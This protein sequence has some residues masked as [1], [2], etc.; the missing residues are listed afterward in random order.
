[1]I[2]VFGANTDEKEF[3]S[4][5]ESIKSGWMGLGKKV[6]EFETILSDKLGVPKITMVD[7]GSNALYLAIKSLNLPPNSI[8]I[9]P[10]FTWVACANA[11]L[12]AGHRIRFCDVE[13]D[14]NISERKIKEVWDRYVKAIMIVHYAGNPVDMDSINNF[15]VPV[16]EDCAHAVVS[17]YKGTPVGILGD[18]GIYSFD[19]VK[20]LAT[21]EGGAVVSKDTE[22]LNFVRQVRYCG[23]NKSGF[24]NVKKEKWWE[25]DISCISH[26]MIP[27]DVSASIGIE[28][29]KKLDE[30]QKKRKIIWDIYQSSFKFETPPEPE[31]GNNHSYFTYLIKVKN[32]DDLANKL[33]KEGVYT[34]LRYHPLHL[35][36][37]YNCRYEL[38]NSEKLAAVGLN[39]P[40]HPRMTD[41]DIDK[42]VNLVHKLASSSIL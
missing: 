22:K 9:V 33:L 34:T 19:S 13:L 40:L 30:N 32:R 39:L 7:S 14:G 26:K 42:V 11:V 29:I 5:E 12:L 31:F 24:A 37:I 10:T 36:K 4:T 25:Y 3:L 16:I 2:S 18:V 20:N 23:I 21:P 27:N 8:I 28:Q 6:D 41:N 1:M 35:N 38:H 17:Q 15:G